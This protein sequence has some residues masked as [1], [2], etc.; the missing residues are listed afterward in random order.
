MTIIFGKGNGIL[1]KGP[2]S[3]GRVMVWWMKDH[4]LQGWVMVYWVKDHLS[5][6]GNCVLAEGLGKLH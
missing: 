3:L 4:H 1:G 2:L 6:L 5:G